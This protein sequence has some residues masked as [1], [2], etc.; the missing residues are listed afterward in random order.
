[1][2]NTTPRTL[3]GSGSPFPDDRHSI[4]KQVYDALGSRSLPKASKD[5]MVV[6]IGVG[7][8]H[9]TEDG[10]PV[11]VIDPVVVLKHPD[12]HVLRGLGLDLEMEINPLG[13]AILEEDPDELV[14]TTP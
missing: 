14:D 4:L 1:M 13:A 12:G 11:L 2:R 3:E 9:Q 5:S 10:H 7:E 6:G 8:D